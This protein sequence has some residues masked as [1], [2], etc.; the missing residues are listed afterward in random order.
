[1]WPRV[2]TEPAVL[3]ETLWKNPADGWAIASRAYAR[4]MHAAGVDVRLSDWLTV[5][6]PP[7]ASLAELRGLNM[8]PPTSVAL[9]IWSSPLHSYEQLGMRLKALAERRTAFYC[10]FERLRIESKLAQALREMNGIWVQCR[11]NR[12]VLLKHGVEDVTLI[13]YP[14]FDDDPMLELPS[15]RSVD[16]ETPMRFLYVG[17]FEPRKSPENIIRAFLRGFKHR[18]NVRLTIKLSPFPFPHEDVNSTPESAILYELSRPDVAANGWTVENWSHAIRIVR[19]KLTRAEMVRLYLKHDVYVSASRGEGLDLPCWDAKVSGMRVVTAPSGGPEDFLGERDIVLPK[20]GEV[21]AD[22][23]YNWEDEATY[24]DYDLN[25]LINAMLN[26]AHQP[27]ANGRDWDTGSH[28][29]AMVG[30]RLRE[31][32]EERKTC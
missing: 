30:E 1:M 19:G 14:L 11:M 16:A 12:D 17:R 24:A 29:A 4:A 5:G 31:W 27:R 3:F 9:S 15:P 8:R 28:R 22:P 10:V 13:P 25:D 32:I 26:A 18:D 6:P 7:E 2:S 21:A 23:R 20:T